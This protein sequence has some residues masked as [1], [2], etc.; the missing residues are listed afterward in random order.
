MDGSRGANPHAHYGARWIL[1]FMN[2]NGRHTECSSIVQ[3]N[4]FLSA[5]RTICMHGAMCLTPFVKAQ[6]LS[7]QSQ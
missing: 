2:N 4:G 5:R 7:T 3:S 6:M 1:N